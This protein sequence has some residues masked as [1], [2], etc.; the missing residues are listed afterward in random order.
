MS[1]NPRRLAQLF[2]KYLAGT[3]TPE[4]LKQFWQLAGELDEQDTMSQQMRHWWTHYQANPSDHSYINEQ[5]NLQRILQKDHAISMKPGRSAVLR[6][7][8]TKVAIAAA[9]VSI[10]VMG[11]WLL[12]NRPTHVPV[13]AARTTPQVQHPATV[14]PDGTKVF[15][16]KNSKLDFPASFNGNTRDV[17]LSGEAYF[18]VAHNAAKPFRVHTGKYVTEVLGTKFNIKAYPGFNEIKVTV[19]Q[20]KVRV[21]EGAHMLNV[22]LPNQQLVVNQQSSEP[23]LSPVD[24][25]R[26]TKW[27]EEEFS[28]QD[29]TLM[30]AAKV[31]AEKY[32]VEIRFKTDAVM[33]CRF[34]G[35]YF[36]SDGLDE[37]IDIICSVTGAQWRKEGDR[38]WLDG[39]GCR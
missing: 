8:F 20:G 1:S 32:G 39:T 15:V 33:Q 7:L 19:S 27:K 31:L 36:S 38:I 9:L 10:A 25:S 5:Q 18:E 22:L 6:P 30:E 29:I 14:L 13:I 21:S 3:C 26:E 11:W 28:F 12:E 2:D 23:Q 35:H 4:E 24:A 34:S 17:Y 16:N 37:I